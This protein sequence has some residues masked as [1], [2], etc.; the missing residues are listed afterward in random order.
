MVKKISIGNIKKLYFMTKNLALNDF[1]SKYA[2]SYFGLLWAL[3]QPLVTILVYW[4]VFEKGL[5]VS[6][7]AELDAPFILWFVAGIIPWFYFSEAVTTSASSYIEYNYLVKKVVFKIELLPLIKIIS[8]FFVHLFFLII[9]FVFLFYNYPIT[10][11]SLQIIYY[12][13]CSVI[14]ISSISWLT[15]AITP[16]LKTL[17][18]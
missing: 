13:L 7:P 4:F 9:M 2:G 15:A 18:M 17:L 8:A 6:G 1:K 10:Y 3:L 11:Y 12:T 16:F 14:L 5:K